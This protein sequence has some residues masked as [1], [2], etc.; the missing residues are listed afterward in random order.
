MAS[1]SGRGRSCW[2]ATLAL[3]QA[4]GLELSPIASSIGSGS[5]G[6]SARGWTRALAAGVFP[7]GVTTAAVWGVSAAAALPFEPG[8]RG[9]P[10]LAAT[11]FLVVLTSL[12]GVFLFPAV[13]GVDLP[14]LPR[15]RAFII[16]PAAAALA[17]SDRPFPALE[18]DRPN[19]FSLGLSA[20]AAREDLPREAVTTVSAAE[21]SF[22]SSCRQSTDCPQPLPLVCIMRSSKSWT[23][24]RK[25][26]TE[27]TEIEGR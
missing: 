1:L 5:S 16:R 7:E 21:V 11:L 22:C 6:C 10:L 13:A 2:T 15:L 3:A 18:A 9:C 23:G 19:T 26:R 20:S 4:R 12:P 14:S 25:N 17:L 24:C 8:C 27:R